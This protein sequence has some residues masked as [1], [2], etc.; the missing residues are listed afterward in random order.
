M[1]DPIRCKWNTNEYPSD[2]SEPDDQLHC[3]EN[4]DVVN[5]LPGHAISTGSVEN[6]VVLAESPRSIEAVADWLSDF[7]FQFHRLSKALLQW[8]IVYVKQLMTDIINR[9]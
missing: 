5:H 2:R 3:S 7:Q 8:V 9:T 6:E 4:N 1:G